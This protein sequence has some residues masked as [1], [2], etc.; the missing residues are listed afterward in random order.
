MAEI[1]EKQMGTKKATCR[2][3]GSRLRY[4]PS[5]ERSRQYSACGEIGTIW[6]I[7]CPACGQDTETRST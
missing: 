6:E 1:I 7:T 5:E 3:C 4:M 2:N